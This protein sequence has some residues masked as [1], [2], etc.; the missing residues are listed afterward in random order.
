M[1]IRDRI[2]LF[3]T[4]WRVRK[5]RAK[6]HSECLSFMGPCLSPSPSCTERNE[7]LTFKA[8]LKLPKVQMLSD[9][10]PRERRVHTIFT[11]A[12]IGHCHECDEYPRPCSDECRYF[13]P[14]QDC[15]A[16]KTMKS[17]GDDRCE[18]DYCVEIRRQ[19]QQDW[20]VRTY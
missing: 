2:K 12:M 17:C 13:G 3:K 8:A 18:V 1:K 14:C 16:N 4:W 10:Q 20:A 19:E 15:V 6:D 11:C 9:W 5:W 7:Y